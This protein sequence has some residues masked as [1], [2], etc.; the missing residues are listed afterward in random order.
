MRSLSWIKPWYFVV[1]L[2]LL[3]SGGCGVARSRERAITLMWWGDL[4]NRAFAQKLVD[5]YNAENPAV[6]VK[7][8]AIEQGGYESKLLSMSAAGIPPDIMLISAGKHLEYAAKGIFLPLDKYAAHPDFESLEKDM[9]PNIW[10]GCRHD[11]K[12]YTVPIWTNSIGIFYNRG[13]FDKAGVSY[14]EGDWTFDDLLNKSQKLTLDFDKDG[15]IDQYGFGGIPLSLDPWN[16]DMLVESFGGHIYSQ[17]GKHCLIGR[18]EAVEAIH[19]AIDIRNKYHISPTTREVRSNG[20]TAASASGEDYFRTGRMAMVFWGRWYLNALRNAKDIDWAV[21]DY[22]RDKRRVM[23]QIPVYLAIASRTKHPDQCWQFIQY[24]LGEKG[25]RL[26]SQ[27]RAEIPV[28]RSIAYSPECVNYAARPD[29][30][31]VFLSMLEYARLPRFVLGSAEWQENA[32]DKLDLAV[33]GSVSVEEACAEIAKEYE[34]MGIG[35]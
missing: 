22:P 20:I 10:E 30:N 35:K 12:L 2:A 13:L 16:L 18:K 7:L 15:R 24:V 33:M 31:K 11:G 4:Y 32:M 9:W 17:D 14:P 6:K 21:A 26:L 8:L 23:Y 29:A 5:A 28:R 19:W 3:V 27:E 1:L 25:Q 34:R